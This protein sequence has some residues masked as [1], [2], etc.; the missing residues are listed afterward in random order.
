MYHAVAHQAG[1]ISKSGRGDKV[2]SNVLRQLVCKVM[3]K[4]PHIHM[5]DG[6]SVIQWLEKRQTIL[7]PSEWVGDLELHLL[8]IGLKRDIAVIT[9]MGNGISTY[10]RRYPC[11]AK[12][13]QKMRGDI[14][15]SL[16]CDNLFKWW[17]AA[18]PSPLLLIFNGF[19]HYDS[20]LFLL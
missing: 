18:V 12:P 5:E 3:D 2:T 10:A 16:A 19:N 13:T 6:L 8:A 7:D 17:Q 20:T 1:F 4:Y 15:I 14:F 11:W 9:S